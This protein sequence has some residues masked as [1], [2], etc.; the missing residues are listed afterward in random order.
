M[1]AETERAQK[2]QAHLKARID[3]RL[4]PMYLSLPDEA[5][6]IAEKMYQ[7]SGAVDANFFG[8]RE[9]M[10]RVAGEI[11]KSKGSFEA[12]MKPVADAKHNMA[13]KAYEKFVKSGDPKDEEAY[14]IARANAETSKG[15][16]FRHLDNLDKEEAK[17]KLSLEKEEMRNTIAEDRLAE[18]ERANAA[19]EE[20]TSRRLDILD[21][22][23][24]IAARNADTAAKRAMSSGGQ[25]SFA[26][27][28]AIRGMGKQLPKQQLLAR[29]AEKNI[30]KIE[31]ME[32]LIDR[33]AGGVRGELIA[34]INKV[35]DLFRRTS[36]EDAK[37]NVLKSEMIGLA[38]SLRLQLGLIGQTSDRDVQIMQE[39]AGMG[40]PAESQKA[41]MEGYKQGF[42]QDIDNYNSDAIAYS[43]HSEVG[44]DLYKPITIQSSGKGSPSRSEWL[45]AAKVKNPGS[46][47]A[48]LGAYYDKKYGG[49]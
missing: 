5:K 46:S 25:L 16:Y 3:F 15:E 24:A 38:G 20:G 19:R 27:K 44:K 28:E 22:N 36:P 34:K 9:D 49:K 47:D 21:K 23:S 26:D 35:A 39:A 37:Y 13:V 43:E 45:K 1:Q 7:G 2:E 31:R 40:T 14:K 17:G 18:T 30:Q 29:T 48:E 33:G 6:P 12:L 8:T 42:M 11:E 32:A 10:Y 4:S 41:L